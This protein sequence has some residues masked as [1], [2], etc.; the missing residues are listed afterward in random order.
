MYLI[1]KKAA[2]DLA[3]EHGI[4]PEDLEYIGFSDASC[5]KPEAKLLQFNIMKSGH[6]LFGGTISWKY[7]Y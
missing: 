5:F 3:K 2:G 6:R 4:K 1:I 7:G